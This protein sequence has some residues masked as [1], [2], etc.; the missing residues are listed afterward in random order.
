[1]NLD[2][3]PKT[4]AFWKEWRFFFF[5]IAVMLVFRSALADWNHVPSG[6]MKPSILI[7]DRV[8]VNKVAYG[9]RIPFTM[10][11]V[12]RWG[13]PKRGDIVTFPSPLDERLFI[14][15]VIGL[16]GDTVEL[17][18]NKL[19]I[20]GEMA[21][22]KALSETE[23]ANIDLPPNTKQHRRFLHESVAGNTRTIML[24]PAARNRQN[25]SFAKITVPENA[26]LV[27][28]DNRDNSGDFRVV[29]WVDRERIIGRAHTIAFSV[30]SD[31]YYAPRMARF[32]QALH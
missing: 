18:R 16:P 32:F 23:V 7:G 4:Q 13:D 8:V 25:Q 31:N 29:G 10:V 6:S 27:L 15:R 9:L 5:F 1:M 19:I 30:D 22:Y 26:Y 21:I 28:G 12:N 17:K 24:I 3:Y 20:N 11:R 14:K 2:N